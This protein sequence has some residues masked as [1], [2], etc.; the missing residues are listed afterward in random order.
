[1]DDCL[2]SLGDATVFSTQA[3]NAR[4]WQIPVAAQ[5]RDETTFTTHTGLFR[6]LRLQFGL[7][8]S[9]ASFQRALDIILSG[10]RWQTCLM[11]LDDV[12]VFSRTADV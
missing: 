3:Y 11:Y 10:L 12:I 9:P 7:V 5:D 4:Y 2:D 6:F 1:M 8:N